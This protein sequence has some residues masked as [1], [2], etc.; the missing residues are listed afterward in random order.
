MTCTLETVYLPLAR[1]VKVTGEAHGP[2]R[3]HVNALDWP[4]GNTPA[5]ANSKE[6]SKILRHLRVSQPQSP[7]A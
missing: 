6:T 2:D 3:T 1:G 5:S 4:A 7:T